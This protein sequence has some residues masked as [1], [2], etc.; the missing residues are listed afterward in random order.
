MTQ[1]IQ[2]PAA[3]AAVGGKIEVKYS[4]TQ[5]THKSR[6]AALEHHLKTGGELLEYILPESVRS[7]DFLYIGPNDRYE[8]LS[9]AVTDYKDKDV[10]VFIPRA[11]VISKMPKPK[12]Y[13]MKY[14][15]RVY[16]EKTDET[17]TFYGVVSDWPVWCRM[18]GKHLRAGGAA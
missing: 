9:I 16:V 18:S 11:S 8:P 14:G 6:D 4:E 2:S 13:P 15:T 7:A 3:A 5:H 12:P 10:S 1:T 17:Y